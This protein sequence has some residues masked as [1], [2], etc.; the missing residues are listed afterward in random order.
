MRNRIVTAVK[1]R[2]SIRKLSI[3]AASVLLGTSLYFMG[4]SS[5]VVHAATTSSE[6]A[7]SSTDINKPVGVAENST[8]NDADPVD[9]AGYSTMN[10]AD[11]NNAIDK[12]AQGKQKELQKELGDHAPLIRA[13]DKQPVTV[14]TLGKRAYQ[15]GK[16]KDKIDTDIEQ[17]KEQA[18]EDNE[19]IEKYEKD[20]PRT[21]NPNDKDSDFFK[22]QGLSIDDERD[23]KINQISVDHKDISL[24]DIT[25]PKD[26][27]QSEKF[28]GIDGIDVTYTNKMTHKEQHVMKIN[29][30]NKVIVDFQH[31]QCSGKEITVTYDNLNNSYY[32]ENI[33]NKTN[34]IKIS[35]IER[36]FSDIH[37]TDNTIFT[38]NGSTP[39]SDGLYDECHGPQ[40]IIYNDPSD[41]FFYNN[42]E[43]VSVKDIYYDDKGDEITF[44]DKD[45]D[46]NKAWIFVTSLNSDGLKDGKTC[47]KDGK[48]YIE[49]VK[50]EI[51]AENSDPTPA[52]IEKLAGSTVTGPVEGNAADTHH[53]W[54][55][56]DEDNGSYNNGPYTGLAWDNNSEDNRYAF[57]GAVAIK[58]QPGLT[59]TYGADDN[60]WGSHWVCTQTQVVSS[61][62]QRVIIYD[63]IK[64]DTE[65]VT[66]ND[67]VTRTIHYLYDNG[68]TAQPDKT[69][70][71]SFNETGTKDDVTGEIT[72]SNDNAQSVDSV[73][74]PSIVGY[75][76][77]KSSIEKQ[78][79]KFGDQDV[80]VTVTYHAN[81]Q[82]AKITYIDDTTKNNLDSQ[83]A[84]GKFG[85]AITF[86]TAPAAE[87]ENYKKK[88]YVFVSNNFDN[89]TYQ[90]VD[91]N[92]VFEVHFK[93][94]TT[95]IDPEHPG[96]G[97]SA[98]DLEKTITRTINYL[99]GE[100]NSVAQAHDDSLKFTA[101][102]TV[103]KVTGKLVSVDD[104]GN[105]TGA[106]QLTWKAE[107][108]GFDHV[109]SPTVRG[110][111]VTNVTPADQKD[112]DNVKEVTVTKDSSDIVVNVY[113][114]PNGTHQKNAKTV[115]STQTVKI[116]DNQGKELRPSIVD[117]FTFSRT[118]DVTDAEGKTTEG[119]WNATEHTY[120]TVAAP[121][122]PGY[123]AEKGRAGGKKATIDNPNVVDQIVYHKL[124]TIIPVTPDHKP[125]P[126]APQP[127]YPNDP[128]DPTN[129]KPNEPIPNVP[130]YTPVDPS[131][132][133][134]QDPTKPTEVIY[135]KT[136]TI[137]VKYHDTT[138]D[139]DLKGYG[140][141]AEGKEN[142]PFTY[143]P[144]S[145][146]KDLEGRGYVVDGEV[147][148]IPNKFSDGP[149]TFVINV[150][151]GTT[152]VTSNNPGKPG[153]PVDPKNPEGPKYP[154]GTELDQ[155]KR[156][157]TQ[158][159]HYVGAGDKTPADN[160][161]TFVFTR[162]ITFD[163]VTGKI[164]SVTP[165]NVQSHTFGN[166]DTPV[167]PGYH[168][169][170][171]VAGGETVTPDDL[172][173]VI[174]VTYAPD[175]G[176]GD[177]PGSNGGGDQGTTPTPEPTPDDQPD[178]KLPSDNN[179]DKDVEKDKQDK[180]KAVKKAR[181]I[182]KTRITKQEHIGNAEKAEPLAEQEHNDQTVASPVKNE[183]NEPQLPQTGEAN[184]S[185]IGLLGMLVADF[186]AILG[187]E[188]SRSR[189]HK[190]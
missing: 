157:G 49:K 119:Q 171:A 104:R 83:A 116:V 163:D 14:D 102:G 63:H 31:N 20:H 90:A 64:D 3:G 28:D 176:S 120:G 93:H 33:N 6:S 45:G 154:K 11:V 112:G 131:P 182:I 135:T 82:I 111:H 181:K 30:D 68:N 78:S 130:G 183:A 89:Q 129:V 147:P 178:T 101:S 164:I 15:V 87:I 189:K 58:Y 1:Q 70:T 103:D 60:A 99:D 61:L 25:L 74:T 137:S 169:D 98:T 97:Y 186:A 57:V 5:P 24:K 32:L 158:T 143:D 173:K 48:T 180:P 27:D 2:F 187:F 95:P 47:R 139:K 96:A 80:E 69:Q 81:A 132:I 115:P 172:N 16:I 38:S 52:D 9:V 141:N 146:L 22:N 148:N 151:H 155:V 55:Y 113:Y 62:N 84:I 109:D 79:F 51:K 128:Q 92:N 179:T 34:R 8:M 21:V 160:K 37:P 53:G 44:K 185:V 41:G 26:K 159:I 170:K 106:G 43:Q 40:L 17:A 10:D 110:M 175:G 75:T 174:T 66:R 149:Q 13:S 138:E 12:Y 18:K 59:I 165:W 184:T 188:S 177:N 127:E 142:D 19:S 167:I 76:P 46:K 105:I 122:I 36:T 166:V 35:K 94:G 65:N 42:I 91:S 168:A 85:Q 114:A 152:T 145:D 118:P 71:V 100:G 190:N 54:W 67:T 88:G 56:S 117:S 77:D 73:N 23:S 121:V 125:I 144:T 123:V 133:T 4:A 29:S 107:T 156:T 124:S 50:A 161:Q 72:W 136:G 108:H 140:T 126:N 7:A 39:T 134:P 162:E 153:E 150:K 86:A